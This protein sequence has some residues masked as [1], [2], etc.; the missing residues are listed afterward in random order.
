VFQTGNTELDDNFKIT[1]LLQIKSI[2]KIINMNEKKL[3]K[4]DNDFLD[5]IK[6]QN[7]IGT[8]S[9]GIHTRIL[10]RVIKERENSN[11]SKRGDG[12]IIVEMDKVTHDWTC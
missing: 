6:K 1:E 4:D 8:L 2:V 5:T 3:K 7:R 12:S 11:K 9:K 10:K